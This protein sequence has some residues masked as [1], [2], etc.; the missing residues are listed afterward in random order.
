MGAVNIMSEAPVFQKDMMSAKSTP[1]FRAQL[2]FTIAV[3][4]NYLWA[5][6]Y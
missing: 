6:E 5:D 3:S 4:F 1:K 2:L